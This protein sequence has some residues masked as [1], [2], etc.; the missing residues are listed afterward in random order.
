MRDL[1]L[2]LDCSTQ[3][4]T[5]LIIDFGSG[6]VLYRERINY[7]EDLPQYNTQN[8]VIILDN[9]KIIHS[10]PLMWVE[11]LDILFE[12]MKITGIPIHNIKAVS[13]SGQQHGTVYLNNKFERNLK[14]LDRNKS[15]FSQLKDSFS[16]PTSPVWMDSSTTN[17]CE[18]I[19]ENLGGLISTIELLGSNTF[20]RF[21][22]P[23]IRKFFQEEPELYKQTSTIHVVSSFMASILLGMNAPIDHGDGA[24]MNLMNMKTKQWDN[25]ALEA[26]APNLRGK[27][28]SLTEPN[29]II[30]TLSSHFIRK[31][32][33]NPDTRL[34][35]WS[36][37]NPNSLIGVGLIEK[38]KVAISLGTSDTYF[39]Y[40]KDLYLDFK[41]EGHVFVAPTGDYMS[42]ICYKNGS[43]ARERI[44]DNFN[45]NWEKFSK[46][47]NN[48]PPGNNGKI[49]LPF[50]FPEIVPL[51]L[52]PHVYRFGFNE[53]DIEG[54]V[55][56]IIE[57][58]FLSIKLHSEWIGEKPSEIYA[59]GGASAN[60]D[61]LQV[62]ANIFNTKVRLFELTD[63]AALGAA[64]RAAKSYY[65]LNNQIK[66][67]N[68]II[69][70]FIDFQKC[71]V[72]EPNNK[73]I[74]LYEDMLML[75]KNY[76]DYVLN[77]GEDPELARLDFIKKYF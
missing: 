12:K 72:L 46:I 36:G 27:L 4:L 54:N 45:L 24:G 43:L 75:Y 66:S 67:W 28:P 17:Q 63:S 39:G 77:K 70:K 2:G 3:S 50:F 34:I 65:D 6:K 13:G 44:K 60:K 33:F 40:L 22:G 53:K 20:E 58:Q 37:D 19:R 48:T 42:L 25:R 7:D 76:E 49:M 18:E 1:F 11:A 69:N 51:V 52:E 32:G 21:S 74:E 68:D 23:Q 29:N 64:F 71:I 59:T 9:E 47:L 16:R 56:G 30:G 55:R 5:S 73:Y 35:A 10:Y 57:A 15:L 14:K 62:L 31:F 8:G 41:G 38:G 26:T 61:I